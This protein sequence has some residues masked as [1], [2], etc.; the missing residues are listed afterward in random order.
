MP[1]AWP[2]WG[3][4]KG[5]LSPP[6]CRKQSLLS[7]SFSRCKMGIISCPTEVLA[8]PGVQGPTGLAHSRR[9]TYAHLGVVAWMYVCSA[10]PH[11]VGGASQE[12]VG[13]PTTVGME[14]QAGDRHSLPTGPPPAASPSPQP[15]AAQ[16]WRLGPSCFPPLNQPVS[17]EELAGTPHQARFGGGPGHLAAL[18]LGVLVLLGW[19]ASWVPP[20]SV[21]PPHSPASS[22]GGPGKWV[23]MMGPGTSCVAGDGRW[24][25]WVVARS[26]G[27]ALGSVG[28]SGLWDRWMAWR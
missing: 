13:L 20:S 11:A 12:K 4:L 10:V 5:A 21:P 2:V 16:G 27:M 25:G 9:S 3:S 15:T 22:G 18:G 26:E 17:T 6:F 14:R 7:L 28:R 1:H 19:E 8:G 23:Q 24:H